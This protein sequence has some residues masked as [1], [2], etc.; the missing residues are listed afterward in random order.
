MC[1]LLTRETPSITKRLMF[2]YASLLTSLGGTSSSRHCSKSELLLAL[3][4]P[5]SDRER[6]NASGAW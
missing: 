5:L 3:K 2:D 4:W 1:P 6:G